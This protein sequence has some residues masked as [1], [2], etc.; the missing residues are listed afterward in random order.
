MAE[1]AEKLTAC[2][3]AFLWE[4]TYGWESVGSWR[5]LYFIERLK[6]GQ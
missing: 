3:I 6:F 4:M 2:F 1:E 5:G